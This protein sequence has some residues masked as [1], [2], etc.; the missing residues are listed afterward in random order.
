MHWGDPAEIGIA[1]L[2]AP[3]WGDQTP[4]GDGE[5]AVFWAC[6]VT[7]QAAIMRAVLPLCITHKPGRMLIT[8]ISSTAETPIKAA[9]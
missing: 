2:A 7:P 5:V 4:L 8:D 3:D 1:D 9:E 6:G